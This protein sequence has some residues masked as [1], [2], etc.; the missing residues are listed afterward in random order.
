MHFHPLHLS[1]RPAQVGESLFQLLPAKPL[2]L[3]ENLWIHD[4]GSEG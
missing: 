2:Q 4:E 3:L 1:K